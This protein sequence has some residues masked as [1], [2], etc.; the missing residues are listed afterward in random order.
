MPKYT[1]WLENGFT[2]D[3]PTGS[4]PE[5]VAKVKHEIEKLLAGSDE[6]IMVEVEEDCD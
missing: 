5:F 2:V 6:D 3:H 1:I 4:G